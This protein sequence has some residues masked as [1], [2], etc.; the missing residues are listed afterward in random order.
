MYHMVIRKRGWCYY[1]ISSWLYC[2]VFGQLSSRVNIIETTICLHAANHR[3]QS[4]KHFKNCQ[5]YLQD[6]FI[7][8]ARGNTKGRFCHCSG[9]YWPAALVYCELEAG[10]VCLECVQS[11]GCTFPPHQLKVFPVKLVSYQLE[12]LANNGLHA[13]GHRL[14]PGELLHAVWLPF[15]LLSPRFLIPNELKAC[16]EVQSKT[17]VAC[18][19]SRLR[20]ISLSTT[21]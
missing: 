14:L 2:I 20:L 6:L 10:A 13:A 7:R 11:A 5:E 18:W 1:S 21:I 3:L 4:I 16:R 9:D 8:I 17:R 15:T 12:F 19:V